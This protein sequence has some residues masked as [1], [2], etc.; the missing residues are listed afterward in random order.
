[1]FL[2]VPVGVGRKR[3]AHTCDLV[4]DIAIYTLLHV[5]WL[6][7]S[8]AAMQD[9]GSAS[10]SEAEPQ[11]SSSHKVR[12]GSR[13]GRGHG[14]GRARGSGSKRAK[15]QD[16]CQ[17]PVAGDEEDASTSDTEETKRIKVAA[18]QWKGH[19]RTPTVHRN[20]DVESESEHCAG[21]PGMKESGL[22]HFLDQTLQHVVTDDDIGQLQR[23]R[24]QP[25]IKIGELCAGMA[26]GTIASRALEMKLQ[27]LHGV[28]VHFEAAFYTENVL[29]KQTVCKTVHA[30]CGGG[31][32]GVETVFK[33]RTA[34]LAKDP[35]SCDLLIGA[36]E[37][38]DISTL[39]TKARS[40]LD[41]GGKSGSSFME[42][43]DLLNSLEV[44]IRPRFVV[45][46]C[47]AALGKM[48][49]AVQEKG[50]EKV[51][52][53][54]KE[55]AY[56]GNWKT[57]NSKCFGLPQSRTR[58]YGIFRLLASG[59]GAEGHALHTNQI[60]GI[61]GMV[62]RCQISQPQTLLSL[63]E[64]AGVNLKD[65]HVSAAKQQKKKA[66][67]KQ[68]PKWVKQHAAFK[69]RFKITEAE[70]SDKTVA[71]LQNAP[72]AIEITQRELEA[73]TLRLAVQL[74]KGKLN[75][76]C[77]VANLGDSLSYLRFSSSLH[78]CVL[79]SKKYIYLLNGQILTNTHCNG[80]YTA[81]Q[82]LGPAEL[83][84]CGLH[85]TLRETEMQELAGN[86]FTSNI[87]AAILLGVLCHW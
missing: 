77:L 5:Y 82:G 57:L 44:A 45:L 29:W 10:T 2:R 55:L 72:E 46:E 16:L 40:V 49:S 65:K 51:S 38:D 74:R 21:D 32:D 53:Q 61:W 64:G 1:M 25:T 52:E 11:P 81:L 83:K 17:M 24:S 79:P 15:L 3:P 87:V 4:S 27:E 33:A 59:F 85:Q 6:K 37:C 41:R 23:L 54:M 66:P 19:R 31:A 69:D 8:Q 39:T 13:G 47:V 84:M 78:P 56:V 12:G 22:L 76:S 80:L 86:A 20:G 43:I 36:L 68:E 71:L 73:A 9:E 63:L 62:A 60:N 58:A 28:T 70:L 42:M 75:P 26:T 67:A 35:K 34:D 18:S 48:R 50:T 30:H 14:G 7:A